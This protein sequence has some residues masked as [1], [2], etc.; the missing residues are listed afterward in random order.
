M[1]PCGG[2]HV[3]SLGDIGR[4][5]IVDRTSKSADTERIEFELV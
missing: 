2:T 4:V 1:C 3:D 5:S